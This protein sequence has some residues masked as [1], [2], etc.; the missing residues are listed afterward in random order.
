MGG[1]ERRLRALEERH[2]PERS[3]PSEE[4]AKRLWLERASARRGSFADEDWGEWRARDLIGLLRL[5][6]RLPTT[7]EELRNRLLAWRPPLDARAVER[8]LA[9]AIYGQEEGTANML[10]P[11]AWRESLVAAEELR[12]KY[13]AVPD[14]TLARWSV[15]LWEREE[16]AEDEA[17]LEE[18]LARE[19]DAHGITEELMLAAAGPDAEEVGEVECGRRLRETLADLHYGEKGY[20]VQQHIDQHL[21]ERSNAWPDTTA[22]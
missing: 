21:K 16:G 18:G 14:E 7:T 9:K 2:G 22:T 11:P 19:A 3:E 20:R 4:E 10:C 17:S 13:M 1:L 5:Q 8:V 15:G 6:G 12:E